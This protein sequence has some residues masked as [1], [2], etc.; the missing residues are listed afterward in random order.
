MRLLRPTVWIA[1]GRYEEDTYVWPRVRELRPKR[2]TTRDVPSEQLDALG[3]LLRGFSGVCN[4]NYKVDGTGAVRLFEINCRVGS[5]LACDVPP[6]LLREFF[7]R[8]D[9]CR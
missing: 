7:A 4:A 8:L 2:L 3:A 6:P 9:G 1:G 5:D